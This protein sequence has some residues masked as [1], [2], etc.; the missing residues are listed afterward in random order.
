M[1]KK[2]FEITKLGLRNDRVKEGYGYK[3]APLEN[4]I[5]ILKEPLEKQHIGYV[6]QFDGSMV[7]I[8]VC[9]LDTCETIIES[10][11]PVI[12]ARNCQDLGKVITYAK[13][14]LLKTVFN[15][16]EVDDL[17]DIDNAEI[18]KK[19][20]AANNTKKTTVLPKAKESFF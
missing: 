6:F 10:Q 2:I 8:T 18:I 16:S 12:E 19:A 20:N 4:V 17:D 9:D 7:S 1:N 11:F 3:Y 14:Y 15:V 5:D 13:R